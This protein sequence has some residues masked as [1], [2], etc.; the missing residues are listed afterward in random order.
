MVVSK[1]ADYPSRARKI[2]GEIKEKIFKETVVD[3]SK[4]RE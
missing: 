4:W 3:L 2:H 1:V